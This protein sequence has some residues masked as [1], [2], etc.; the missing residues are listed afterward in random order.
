MKSAS[1]KMYI[2]ITADAQTTTL[3]KYAK[4]QD[5]STADA[6]TSTSD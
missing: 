2:Q 3:E 4:Q 5:T 1:K 6:Q